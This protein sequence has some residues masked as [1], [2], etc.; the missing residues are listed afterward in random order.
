MY[1]LFDICHVDHIFV[2]LGEL[3]LQFWGFH[4]LF[5]DIQVSQLF[6]DILY[7]EAVVDLAASEVVN[8][9]QLLILHQGAASTPR[10]KILAEE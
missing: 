6:H 10:W 9:F 5:Q 2:I 4:V 8:G 7:F 1:F 3:L